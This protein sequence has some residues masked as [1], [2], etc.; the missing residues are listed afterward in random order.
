MKFGRSNDEWDKM[1]DDAV[2]FLVDQARLKRI[3]SYSDLNSALARRGHVPFNFDLESGRTAVG[4]LLGDVVR[5][6]IG[7]SKVMLSAIVAYLNRNDAGPGFFKFATELGLLPSTATAE[8]KLE[9]WSVQVGKAHERYARPSR[10][11]RSPVGRTRAIAAVAAER[12]LSPQQYQA[13]EA[14]QGSVHDGLC[15]VSE[16]DV[17]VMPIDDCV[18]IV[19][20]DGFV[21]R[22]IPV[23]NPI[24]TPS[25]PAE[26]RGQS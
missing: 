18:W 17:E 25:S 22:G 2:A 14:P 6:T 15:Y 23:G 24:H 26:L 20:P 12:G 13:T 5:Q 3:V 1:V 4:Y 9:F 11:S 7:D 21:A 8:D 16:I 19:F 10:T